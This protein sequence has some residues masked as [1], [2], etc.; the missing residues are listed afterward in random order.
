[1]LIAKNIKTLFGSIALLITLITFSGF[2]AAINNYQRPQ[3]EQVITP[4]SNSGNHTTHYHSTIPLKVTLNRYTIF[5]F[6]SLLNTQRFNLINTQR[7]NLTIQ[8]KSQE[9]AVLQFVNFNSI[10]EQNLIAKSRSNLTYKASL[11]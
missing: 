2:T 11:E 6:K 8:F 10:L 5:S 7:F 9:K 1:M 4:R 3:T